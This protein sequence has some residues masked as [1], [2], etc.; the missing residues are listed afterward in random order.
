[1]KKIKLIILGLFPIFTLADSA[2]IGNGSIMSAYKNNVS[3]N[4]GH[5]TDYPFGITQDTSKLHSLSGKN[6][7]FFQWF[8][9]PN[10]CNKLKVTAVNAEFTSYIHPRVNITVGAWDTR[11]T[12]KTFENVKLPF[13]IGKENVKSST[14]FE[15]YNWLVTAIEV[16]DGTES[17]NIYMECTDE[18]ETEASYRFGYQ[19]NLDGYI[20]N[21]SGSIISNY[22][23]SQYS[24]QDSSPTHGSNPNN[25]WSYGIFKDWLKFSPLYNKQAVFFQWQRSDECSQLKIDILDAPRDKKRVKLI[26]KKWNESPFVVFEDYVELPYILENEKKNLWTVVGVYSDESFDKQ[27]TVE[28]SCCTAPDSNQHL[29]KIKYPSCKQKWDMYSR[30]KYEK[31]LTS[32]RDIITAQR[33]G[34]DRGHQIIKNSLELSEYYMDWA[35]KGSTE[36]TKR[37]LKMGIESSFPNGDTDLVDGLSNILADIVITSAKSVVAIGTANPVILADAVKG[38][39][40]QILSIFNDLNGAFKLDNLTEEMYT[41]L[42]V[43]YYL[44]DYYAWG[45]DQQK[46]ATQYGLSPNS[47]LE[48][49]IDAVANKHGS[50][51][52]WW[53]TE[54]FTDNAKEMIENIVNN[55]IPPHSKE[56]LYKG[57]K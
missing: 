12:D 37:L 39:T 27:Y 4:N 38:K 53:G 56:C 19:I 15:E 29:W 36:A 33:E 24:N 41:S 1:M 40:T 31:V 45:G 46:V 3:D 43:T 8:L 11:K 23:T 44:E 54:Y 9:D 18:R 52:N 42:V 30:L 55:I 21:G 14:W 47:S 7:A 13:T 48:D 5:R 20:W 2:W 26:S 16:E 49:I 28:A 34:A 22:F 25:Q 10:S 32:Q 50:Y 17:G 57:C 35:T 51:N 6:V